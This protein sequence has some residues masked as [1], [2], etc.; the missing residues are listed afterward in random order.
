[1][2]EREKLREYEEKRILIS[3]LHQIYNILNPNL[4]FIIGNEGSFLSLP[5]ILNTPEP[6]ISF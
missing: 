6:I 5:N 1:M 3:D 2:T 4:K